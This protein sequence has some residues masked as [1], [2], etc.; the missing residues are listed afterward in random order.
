[1]KVLAENIK[2]IPGVEKVLLQ[3][4]APMGFAQMS[5]T[6]KFKGKEEIVLQPT[7]EIGNEGYIPFYQMKLIAGRNIHHSDSLTE[8]VI[9][10]TLAKAI[11]FTNARD[12]IGQILYSMGPGGDKGEPI[13]GVIADFHQG[14]FHDAILPG[15]IEN[16]P[17]N[18]KHSIA[19]KLAADEKNVSDVKTYY[20][21]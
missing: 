10:E 13:V 8:L 14:S 4:S 12:A 16:A 1:M 15:I 20:L 17:D 19:I 18:E 21:K 11:G 3:F 2:H 7:I 6:Y 9:N 5:S